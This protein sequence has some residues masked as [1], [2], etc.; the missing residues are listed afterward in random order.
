MGYGSESI[1]GMSSTSTAS[2]RST[3]RCPRRLV[4]DLSYHTQSVVRGISYPYF[5]SAGYYGRVAQRNEAPTIEILRREVRDG[6]RFLLLS[7]T[8]RSI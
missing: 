6:L 5:P 2:R 3:E 8:L 1:A 4:F 7:G